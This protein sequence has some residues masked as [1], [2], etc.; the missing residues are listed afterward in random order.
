MRHLIAG[1][2]SIEKNFHRLSAA[3]EHRILPCEV[4]I[5]DAVRTQNKK[6]LT[7]GSESGTA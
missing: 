1:I 2:Q 7:I 3:D 6:P 5:G 4:I